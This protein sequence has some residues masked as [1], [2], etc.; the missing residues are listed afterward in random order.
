MKLLFRLIS[1]LTLT[2]SI[3]GCASSPPA[4]SP[5]SAIFSGVEPT[6]AYA[7]AKKILVD[8]G[9]RILEESPGEFFFAAELVPGKTSKRILNAFWDP[10][11]THQDRIEASVQIRGGAKGTSVRFSV[12]AIQRR[13]FGADWG[14]EVDDDQVYRTFQSLMKN[15]LSEAR[16]VEHREEAPP[17][18]DLAPTSVT[19]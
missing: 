4:E 17:V 3:C 7:A 5:H 16:K 19:N 12:Q 6:L 14:S 10:T 13:S 11:V 8:D 1:G 2:L 18:D 15:L 9:F